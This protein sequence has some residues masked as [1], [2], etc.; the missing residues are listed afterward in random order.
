MTRSQEEELE[1][2]LEE[3]AP[4]YPSKRVLRR[5]EEDSDPLRRRTPQTLSLTLSTCATPSGR[6]VPCD[7]HQQ[8]R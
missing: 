7:A 3:D 6:L 8:P 2:E 4:S 1:E 5:N